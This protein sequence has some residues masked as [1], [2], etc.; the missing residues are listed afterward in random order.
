[1]KD[2]PTAPE[3][4]VHEDVLVR[5]QRMTDGDAA[6]G[7]VP[8]YHFRIEN[9]SGEDVGHINFRV[10]ITDHV[11]LAAGHIGFEIHQQY[12]G[13]AYAKKACLALEGWLST[14]APSLLITADPGNEPSLKTIERIGAKFMDEVDVPLSDPHYARGSRHMRRFMWTPKSSKT[15]NIQ[16]SRI[17][18]TS[19]PIKN[20]T[21]K[22]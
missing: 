22:R 4:S 19:D 14:I 12:R 9:K 6:K 1:M 17:P 13:N 10:G 5:F 11:R 7:F 16:F 3:K 15:Q 21:N 8:G 20:P 18:C 2:L